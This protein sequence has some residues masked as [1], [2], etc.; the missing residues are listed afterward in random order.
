MKTVLVCGGNRCSQIVQSIANGFR[1]IGCETRYVAT[2]SVNES[3]QRVMKPGLEDELVEHVKLWKPNILFWVIC[4][5]DCPVG[6][7][8]KLRKLAPSMATV[9]H[10][11]DDPYQIDNDPPPIIPEFQF[12]VTC[13]KGSVPWYESLGLKAICLYPP[14][15]RDVHLARAGN[16]SN[17]EVDVSFVATHM[18][19]KSYFPFVFADRSEIVRAAYA[20]TKSVS[21]YGYWSEKRFDWGREFGVP[22]LKDCYRGFLRFEDQPAVYNSTRVNL[23]S[24]VKPDG[25]QYLNERTIY[26][27]GSGGFLLVDHVNGIEE[28][29]SPGR[30]LDTW[31]TLPEFRE[32]L[33]WWLSHPE[34]R[35]RVAEAG[36]TQ[37]WRHYSSEAH[38]QSVLS[39]VS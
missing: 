8:S 39:L 38:C 32:K 6:L 3:G 34:E 29:F 31:K 20:V 26:V 10:S 28:L 22:E 12:A 18:Y 4:K 33:A 23:S 9:F 15:D 16:Q 14:V 37:V 36:R 25:F 35:M 11:F 7:I 19:P 13:C 1:R 24:H 5:W 27:M 17:L 21:L 30:H 2:R